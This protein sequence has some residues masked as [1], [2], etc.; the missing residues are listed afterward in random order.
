MDMDIRITMCMAFNPIVNFIQPIIRN[1]FPGRIVYQTSI[2]KGI[3]GIRLNTPIVLVNVFF[4]SM[5]AIHIST[6]IYKT[7]DMLTLQFPS[8]TEQHKR[9]HHLEI[10]SYI[11]LSFNDVLN[12]FHIKEVCIFLFLQDGFYDLLII[13][14]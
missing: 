9:A 1:D 13:R 14:N 10:S 8:M 11:E 7:I 12:V 4:H 6:G 5:A 3:I 2:G